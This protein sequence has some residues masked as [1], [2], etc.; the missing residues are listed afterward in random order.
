M[1]DKI[2]INGRFLEN[3]NNGIGRFSLELCLQLS[4]QNIDIVLLLPKAIN[5]NYNFRYKKIGKLNS[6]LWEQFEL[7]YYLTKIGNPLLICFSGIG[8][9]LYKNKIITIHDLSFYKNPF[10]FK[11]NYAFIYSILTP[12]SLIY[13]KKILTVSEFSKL[14]IINRLGI[15]N[16]K[17]S[18]IYN[19]VSENLIKCIEKKPINFQLKN[20]CLTISSLDPRKNIKTIIQIAKKSEKIKFVLVGKKFK[21]F[22]FKKFRNLPDNLIWIENA[23]DENLKYLYKHADFFLYLSLY[24]GFGIPPIESMAFNC[25]VICSEIPSLKEVC[26]DSAQFVNPL[27]I[28]DILNSIEIIT[29]NDTI[30]NTFIEKG[31]ITSKLYNWQYS[32]EKLIKIIDEST[33]TC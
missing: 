20:Y 33:S 32:A 21:N 26:K 30:K 5:C 27:N 17:I 22:N 13:Y 24:E 18:V 28:N 4:K 16:N 25:P 10:W 12:L 23:T 29:N 2:Y 9:I 11:I 15:K 6:H 3:V 1:K 31:L 7:P 8:P 14:E 19:A